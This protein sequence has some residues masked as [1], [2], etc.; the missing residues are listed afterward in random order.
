MLQF[1]IER[2]SVEVYLPESMA[3]RMSLGTLVDTTGAGHAQPAREGSYG[4]G[5][6]T[7]MVC[8]VMGDSASRSDV[9]TTTFSN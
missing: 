9:S 5:N 2:R 1:Q 3:S 4:G 6:R 7:C 8:D